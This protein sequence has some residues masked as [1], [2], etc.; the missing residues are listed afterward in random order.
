MYEM[1]R[2]KHNVRIALPGYVFG[3]AWLLLYGLIIASGFIF[4]REY[5]VDNPYYLTTCILYLVNI[6]LNKLWPLA[7]F[8][9]TLNGRRY[10]LIILIVLLLTGA[11][12]LALQLL[13]GALLPG[14]LYAAYLA[15]L[16]YALLLNIKWLWVP[17]CLRSAH[18]GSSL[19]RPVGRSVSAAKYRSAKPA[20]SMGGPSGAPPQKAPAP[21]GKPHRGS[22]PRFTIS[23]K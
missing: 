22:I 2:K 18:D 10:A 15:W 7:F 16:V 4:F 17:P 11:A 21:K 3:P 6:L 9:L 5:A 8:S 20:Q 12:V 13:S 19:E 1:Q 23:A 14:L